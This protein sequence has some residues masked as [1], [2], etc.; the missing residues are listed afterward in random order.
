MRFFVA[1]FFLLATIS[2]HANEPA[3]VATIMSSAKQAQE[4]VIEE[5]KSSEPK[6]VPQVF[7][8]QTQ[9]F[10]Y[11]IDVDNSAEKV[12]SRRDAEF[13]PA[14]MRLLNMLSNTLFQDIGR[15]LTR[16]KGE[17]RLAEIL[18]DGSTMEFIF[19]GD[20]RSGDSIFRLQ[21]I[22]LVKP[23]GADVTLDGAPVDDSGKSLART[24]HVISMRSMARGVELK[25]VAASAFKDLV[26]SDVSLAPLY[27]NDVD[28]SGNLLS[29]IENAASR[30]HE[31]DRAQVEDLKKKIKTVKVPL[32]IRGPVLDEL[33]KWGDRL[34]VL[35][36]SEFQTALQTGKLTALAMKARQR[37]MGEFMM[38]IVR[39]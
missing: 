25:P 29:F 32:T 7:D 8:S 22:V 36:R 10:G 39:K 27:K 5:A 24:A 6:P 20:K 35:N 19:E 15:K 23:N 13:K 26:A 34:S 30:M 11:R 21:K 4:L 16:E 33:L 18:D 28:D 37:S 31:S 14:T 17:M 12:T 2:A 1:A 9:L 38:N 3:C